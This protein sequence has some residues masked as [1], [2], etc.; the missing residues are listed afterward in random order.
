MKDVY[1]WLDTEYNS[2]FS[3]LGFTQ[4]IATTVKSFSKEEYQSAQTRNL[5]IRRFQKKCLELLKDAINGKIDNEIAK[6]LIND[7]P[8]HMREDYLKTLHDAFW[9]EPVFFRTDESSTGKLLEIQCPGSQWGEMQLL[10][11]FF[12]NKGIP[13]AIKSPAQNF[14]EQLSKYLQL[15]KGEEPLVFYLT[16]NASIPIGVRYF[17]SETRKTIPRI[18]YW[19]VDKYPDGKKAIDSHFIRTHYYAELFAECDFKTRIQ[20]KNPQKTWYDLPPMSLFDQKAALALPFWEKTKQFF[21]NEIKNILAYTYPVTSDRLV[22]ENGESMTIA[23]F[24]MKPQSKRHYYIKYAGTDAASNWGSRAVYDLYSNGAKKVKELL[25]QALD[26]YIN[27][28]KPWILQKECKEKKVSVTYYEKDQGLESTSSDLNTKYSMYYG[29]YD[30][31]GGVISYRREKK[32]HG[33]PNTIIRLLYPKR[34]S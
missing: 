15:D 26:D 19:G 3:E 21:D 6:W 22:L 33:Q 9:N 29:P 5:V 18:R 23:E 1:D 2:F 7:T 32:V 24:C 28:G 34:S 14:V 12:S 16:D 10:Y 25:E 8:V 31:I 13:L 30:L 11:N 4:H 27:F 17:I 20:S